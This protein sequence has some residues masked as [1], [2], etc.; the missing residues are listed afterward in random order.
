MAKF[1]AKIPDLDLELV[2]LQK[3]ELVLR[4]K[5]EVSATVV[6]KIIKDWKKIEGEQ[7]ETT[8][9]SVAAEELSMIYDKPSEWFMNSFDITTLVEI[10]NH[11]ANV[12]S[13][14]K[15]TTSDSKGPSI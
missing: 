10:L 2:T 7:D 6:M 8:G 14:V 15:K 5:I 9:V 3:E 1:E 13:G 11:V 12:M 4:P